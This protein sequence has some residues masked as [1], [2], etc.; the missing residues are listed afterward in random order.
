MHRWENNHGDGSE[1]ADPDYQREQVQRL[2]M[3]N[4]SITHTGSLVA[5]G[6]LQTTEFF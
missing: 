4:R 6:P 2:P 5:D 3:T 1:A